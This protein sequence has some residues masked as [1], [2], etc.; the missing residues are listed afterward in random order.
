MKSYIDFSA[1]KIGDKFIL[2]GGTRIYTK[3]STTQGKYDNKTFFFPA[4]QKVNR[5]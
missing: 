5:V 2:Y 3:T 4:I 1:L